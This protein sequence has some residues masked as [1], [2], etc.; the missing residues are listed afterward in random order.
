MQ[1]FTVKIPI[2]SDNQF[3]SAHTSINQLNANITKLVSDPELQIQIDKTDNTP[4]CLLLPQTL[5]EA[6][7]GL[8]AR[9][10]HEACIVINLAAI[11]NWELHGI[12]IENAFLE[13][14]LE[15]TIYMK[16]LWVDGIIIAGN[17]ISIIQR[18]IS[19]IECTVKK[20]SN[21]GEIT[22]YIGNDLLRNRINHTLERT[23]VPKTKTVI[24]KLGPNLKATN[25]PLNPCHDYH[26]KNEGEV[27]TPLHGELG[28]L[29]YLSDR[30]KPT[31]QLPL[32]LLQTGAIDP[33]QGRCETHYQISHWLSR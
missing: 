3:P 17:S 29:G 4:Q 31:L 28:S 22:R 15:E 1:Q 19:C 12:D 21:L 2:N 10:W 20:I 25:V 23:Q 30:R 11:Y 26:T 14:D 27:N 33:T 5:E 6:L 18:V 9:H 7:F 32:S 16:L 24:A 8:D 13:S